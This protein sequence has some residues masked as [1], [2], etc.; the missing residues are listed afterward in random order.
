MTKAKAKADRA[1]A[2][3]LAAESGQLVASPMSSRAH[4][5]T[6]G[7]DEVVAV[8]TP[9]QSNGALDA[10]PV[11]AAAPTGESAID[12]V[13]LLR[14]NLHVANRFI[15]LV[16]PILVDVYAASVSPTLRIKSLTA[17]LKAISFQ[18]IGQL[19]K[20]LKVRFSAPVSS[21]S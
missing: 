4:T 15:R 10:L 16:V 2:R 19:R 1:A 14:S 21:Q 18:E 9:E 13:E 11:L 5:P 8:N 17:I 12:R 3:A 6:P 20:T 7:E